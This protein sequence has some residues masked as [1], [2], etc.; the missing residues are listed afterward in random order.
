MQQLKRNI[1]HLSTNREELSNM[2]NKSK[3]L[4]GKNGA[5]TMIDKIKEH[6]LP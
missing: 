5:Q 6:L 3:G 2:H 4:V 1:I